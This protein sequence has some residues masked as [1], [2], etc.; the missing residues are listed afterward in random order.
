MAAQPH[1][2]LTQSSDDSAGS[3][4]SSNKDEASA[5]SGLGSVVSSPDSQAQNT[6]TLSVDTLNLEAAQSTSIVNRLSETVAQL[7]KGQLSQSERFEAVKFIVDHIQHH[8]DQKKRT[9]YAKFAVKTLKSMITLNCDPEIQYYLGNL[10]I[11]GVPGDPAPHKSNFAKAYNMYSSAAKKD[12]LES[13]YHVA[14][15]HER[16]AGTSTNKSKAAHNYKKAAMLNHPGAMYRLGMSLLRG[17]LGQAKNARDGVKWLRLSAKYATPKYSHALYELAMLHDQGVHNVVWTDHEYL[18]N[19]LTQ[20]AALGHTAAQYRL[21]E[22]Y[23][24]AKFGVSVDPGRSVYYYSLAASNGHPEAMFELGGWFLTGTDDPNTG[25][26]LDQSDS[27]AYYWVYKAADKHRLPRAMF[28]VGYFH[29][30]GVGCAV[31]LEKAME[32]YKLASD[33]GDPKAIKRLTGKD[34]EPQPTD[35]N[36]RGKRFIRRTLSKSKST[37]CTIC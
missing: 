19:L 36:K 8:P 9:D 29:E 14:L 27:D 6:T 3:T 33:A 35:T 18:I 7:Q 23:E 37:S 32:W 26:H 21:G 4:L 22:A 31:D 11:G 28:A 1:A 16:G 12:H 25:F 2:K 10:Y 24:Y 13:I 20:A 15:C 17:D 30:T 34:P 5:A